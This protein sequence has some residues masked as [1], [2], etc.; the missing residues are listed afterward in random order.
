MATFSTN[1]GEITDF[2]KVPIRDIFNNSLDIF[3]QIDANTNR[4]KEENTAVQ[5]RNTL[6][7]NEADTIVNSL[8]SQ[9]SAPAPVNSAVMEDYN[10]PILTNSTTP[11]S[12][13]KEAIK[14]SNYGYSSDSSPDYNSNT[15]K[16]GHAN[17]PLKDG[18][19]AALTKSLAKRYGLKTGDMFEV[20]LADG[21]SMTRRYDDT[22]PNSYRGKA[23][24]ETI[25]L[26]ELKGNNKF[27]G[28]V[29]GIKPVK[30]T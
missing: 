18:V 7:S 19:S 5:D 2:S 29:I 8:L 14:L 24:P 11:I 30:N 15:L 10:A 4:L 27:G 28:K 26:Y 23:L 22:V 6:N 3:D 9:R 1:P 12:S 17:N 21:T 13:G 16:I 25:D 20:Q